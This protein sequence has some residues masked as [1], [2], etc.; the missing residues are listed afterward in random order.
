M[1]RCG[2]IYFTAWYILL[3]PFN[4]LYNLL[5]VRYV[6]CHSIH[7]YHQQQRV[8]YYVRHYHCL[9]DIMHFIKSVDDEE[10]TGNGYWMLPKLLF[11]C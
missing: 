8:L 11:V 7:R 9:C 10:S 3:R 5:L 1:F 6:L 4:I 2:S